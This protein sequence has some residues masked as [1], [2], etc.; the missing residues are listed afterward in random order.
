MRS[1]CL[2]AAAAGVALEGSQQLV[3]AVAAEVL[4]DILRKKVRP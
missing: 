2:P 1:V 3:E 4:A